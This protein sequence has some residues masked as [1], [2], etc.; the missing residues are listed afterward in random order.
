MRW[1]TLSSLLGLLLCVL[2]HLPAQATLECP[3]AEELEVLL[4]EAIKI[5]SFIG[6]LFYWLGL[7][8]LPLAHVHAEGFLVRV[9][10]SGISFP[11]LNKVDLNNS[12]VLSQQMYVM[13]LSKSH[14]NVWLICKILDLK[15]KPISVL[16]MI[17][18]WSNFLFLF[19]FFLFH[20][21][22]TYLYLVF[23]GTHIC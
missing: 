6:A 19:C 12:T 14:I 8:R 10:L 7:W 9:W 18:E 23:L 1:C 22:L 3:L 16:A 15:K 11:E 20:N 21:L 4:T 5:H 17:E 2:K 13:E